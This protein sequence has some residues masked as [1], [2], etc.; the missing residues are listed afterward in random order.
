M[1]NFAVDYYL[2]ALVANVGVIQVAASLGNL[3][4]LLVFKS[5]LLA[6]TLGLATPVI[7]FVWFFTSE[8]RNI[9]D[10]EGGLDGNDQALL[11]FLGTI[12]ATMATSLLTSIINARMTGRGQTP[13]DGLTAL[14]RTSYLRAVRLS[15]RYWRNNWRA[16]T[17]SYFS[18]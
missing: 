11:F 3:Q 8:T 6:R 15:L 4:G 18:G 16:Q 1:F 17:K 7:A 10:Y 9:N 13:I 14:T 5:P 12:S 2:F